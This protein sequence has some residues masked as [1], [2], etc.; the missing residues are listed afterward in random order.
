MKIIQTTIGLLLYMVFVVCCGSRVNFL[1]NV[2]EI[3]SPDLESDST[4]KYT[5]SDNRR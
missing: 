2:E 4:K 3:D 1:A 5:V